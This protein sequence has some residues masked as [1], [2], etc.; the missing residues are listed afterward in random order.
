MSKLEESKLFNTLVGGMQERGVYTDLETGISHNVIFWKH[1]DFPNAHLYISTSL[2]TLMQL[3]TVIESVILAEKL[4]GNVENIN[5]STEIESSD[6]LKYFVRNWVGNYVT[7]YEVVLQLINVIF[8]LGYLKREAS[9]ANIE[10]DN[11]FKEDLFLT[12]R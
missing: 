6:L 12:K 2:T 7:V 5:K 1:S 9:K 10:R 4:I 8:E 11:V 3:E